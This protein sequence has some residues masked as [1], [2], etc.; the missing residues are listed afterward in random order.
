MI[1]STAGSG[2]TLGNFPSWRAPA[3]RLISRCQRNPGAG[4]GCTC[5]RRDDDGEFSCRRLE[6]L[7]AHRR[8]A[9]MA[10]AFP[11][12]LFAICALLIGFSGHSLTRHGEAIARLTSLSRSWIGLILLATAISIAIDDIAYTKGSL[13]AT[14]RHSLCRQHH[15]RHIHRCRAVPTGQPVS[16]P[17]RLGESG[18]AVGLSAQFLCDISTWTLTRRSLCDGAG[19]GTYLRVRR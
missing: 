9:V 14:R 5:D 18:A 2:C 12:L 19:S 7:L 6:A 4:N 1:A 8:K 13:R 15:E 10:V 16:R 3:G 11:W 17:G